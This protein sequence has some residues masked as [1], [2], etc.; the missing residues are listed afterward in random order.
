MAGV[1]KLPPIIIPN[2]EKLLLNELGYDVKEFI[3][4]GNYGSVFKGKCNQNA[5]K[6]YPITEEESHRLDTNNIRRIMSKI[7][8]KRTTY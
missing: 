5:T 4:S 3:G 8:T 2:D 7:R 1:G 6:S